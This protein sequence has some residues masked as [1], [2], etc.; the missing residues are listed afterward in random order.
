MHIGTIS[1]TAS[2]SSQLSYSAASSR[3]TNVTA[4]PKAII[5][6]LPASF[7]CSAISVHSKPKP[8][9]SRCLA[10]ISIAAIAW[11]V[12]KPRAKPS[13][14]SAAGYRLYRGTRNGPVVSRKVATEPIGTM[15]P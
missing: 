13:C 6:V 4:N 5:A 15:S 7:S 12:E 2:G 11:P 10:I 8:C 9:G 1:T 3:N 14:T